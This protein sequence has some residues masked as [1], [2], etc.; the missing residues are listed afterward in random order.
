MARRLDF[1]L[2]EVIAA[3]LTPLPR[4]EEAH[5]API[6]DLDSNLKQTYEEMRAMKANEVEVLR[7]HNALREHLL[8]LQVGALGRQSLVAR[9]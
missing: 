5:L 6:P 3:G 8:V 9:P 4:D 7:S 2:N 1:L